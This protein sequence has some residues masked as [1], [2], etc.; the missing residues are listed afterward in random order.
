LVLNVLWHKQQ[1]RSPTAQN[2]RGAVTMELTGLVWWLLEPPARDSRLS[3]TVGP[4][5]VG[6]G[7]H[8]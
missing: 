2:S 5:S 4:Q 1:W 3:L 8:F 6:V 7:G